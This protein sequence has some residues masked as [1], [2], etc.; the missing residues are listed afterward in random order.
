MRPALAADG[1]HGVDFVRAAIAG[2][3]WSMAVL[4]AAAILNLPD[5]AIG[6]GFVRNRVWDALSGLDRPTPLGDIDLIYH[7]LHDATPARDTALERR[8]GTLMPGVK[9]SVK[10][11]A[12]MHLRN[13]DAPY[14]STEDALRVWIETPTC[15]AVRLGEDERVEVI[16]PHGL[17]DLLAMVVRPTPRGRVRFDDYRRRI[18]VKNWAALWPALRIEEG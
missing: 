2:H 7:D 14:R 1:R 8:L 3:P 16:A 18:A 10:N 11:Q 6:A 15:V 17:G 12:R 5:W 9:W 4:R 13:G